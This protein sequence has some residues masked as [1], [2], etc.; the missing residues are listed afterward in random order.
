MKPIPLPPT[1]TDVVRE[2]L[3]RSKKVTGECGS[4]YTVVTYNLAIAKIAKQIKCEE[5]PTF[6]DI[7]W[8][9]SH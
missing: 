6:N 3:V 9:I 7:F 1:R 4:K 8:P 2:S 5:S